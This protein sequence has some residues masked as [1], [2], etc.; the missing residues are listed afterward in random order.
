VVI[1]INTLLC[2]GFIF[3]IDFLSQIDLIFEMDFYLM[4]QAQEELII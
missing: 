1:S 4:Q 3:L 2:Q